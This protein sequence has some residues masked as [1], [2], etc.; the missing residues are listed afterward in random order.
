[1]E[2]VVVTELPIELDS[3][4]ALLARL[5][6]A[7]LLLPTFEATR[8]Q[9]YSIHTYLRERS[10]YVATFDALL[11]RNVLSCVLDLEQ[12]REA[13]EQHRDAAALMAF[14]QCFDMRIDPAL[15]LYEYAAPHG[16]KSSQAQLRV[17]RAADNRSPA[18]WASVAL[19]GSETL[20]ISS[21]ST[22]VGNDD[23]RVD[24]EMPLMR[25]RR[26]YVHC[27]KIAEIELRGGAPKKRMSEYLDWAF[28]VYQIG[29][30]PIA[31][32]SLLFAPNAPRRGLFQGLWSVDRGRALE[33]ARRATWDMTFLS[34]YIDAIQCQAGENHVVF[35]C[36]FDAGLKR[37]ARGIAGSPDDIASFWHS[38][39]G[40]RLGREYLAQ[41]TWMYD[42]L[43]H[44]ARPPANPDGSWGIEDFIREGE[45]AVT[46]WRAHA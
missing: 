11:D 36:S 37:V 19:G 17:F 8:D 29:G 33:R 40:A 26:N 46:G 31:L 14:L 39:W 1:V 20:T 6:E 3:L 23:P 5:A 18:D 27:L 7:D 10:L 45:I 12:G 24:F 15:A 34:R 30:P 42:N 32:A 2:S 25:W 9:I 43:D 44:P 13:S 28:R 35:L 16:S 41:I 4:A 38:L 21:T 22:R